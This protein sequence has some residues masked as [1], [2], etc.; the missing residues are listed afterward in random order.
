MKHMIAVALV[1]AATA[2]AVSAQEE[3]DGLRVGT[4]A[5][6][7]GIENREPV[8]V[9]TNF[10]EPSQNLFCFTRIEGAPDTL[11]VTHVWYFE[12]GEVGRKDLAVKS[13]S[14]RTWSSKKMLDKWSGSWRVD[15]LGPDGEV[16]RSQEFVYKPVKESE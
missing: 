15:V 14:W 2:L 12:D 3:E 5:I 10:F 16:L 11:T 8:G 6:C 9:S 1:L 13:M 7:T 4:M